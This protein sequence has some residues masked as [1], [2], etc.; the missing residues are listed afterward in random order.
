LPTPSTFAVWVALNANGSY[1]DVSAYLDS[2]AGLT[3]SSGRKN[4]FDPFASGSVTFTLTN[5]DGRFTPDNPTTPYEVPL[6][7]GLRFTWQLNSRVVS[8]YVDSLEPTFENDSA[9]WAK[10]TVT[11]SDVMSRL[12]RYQ[13][14]SLPWEV[15]RAA[16]T[17]WSLGEPSGATQALPANMANTLPLVPVGDVGAI[18]FGD[19]HTPPAG[20]GTGALIN[21]GSDAN[22]PRGELVTK[23][24]STPAIAVGFW[25]NLSRSTTTQPK[26]VLLAGRAGVTP[27]IGLRQG[28]RTS[29][30]ADELFIGSNTF[31]TD[32]NISGNTPHFVEIVFT[33]SGGPSV[34]YVNVAY[35]L[36]GVQRGSGISS[37]PINGGASL[38]FDTLEF[39][40]DEFGGTISH[41]MVKTSA[42]L[43]GNFTTSIYPF[44]AGQADTIAARFARISP[45]INAFMDGVGTTLTGTFSTGTIGPQ[46]I[47][48]K[49]M[50][51]TVT[52]IM[53]VEAGQIYAGTSGTATAPTREVIYKSRAASRPT[54]V[55]S[56]FDVWTDLDG[57]P[58]FIRD[59]TLKVSVVNAASETTN[60]TESNTTL[61]AQLGDVSAELNAPAGT[62]QQLQYLA[63]DRIQRGQTTQLRAASFTIDLRTTPTDRF[64]EVVSLTQGDRTQ[65]Q[66]LPTTQLGYSTWDSLVLGRDEYHDTT[67]NKVTIYA[68]PCIPTYV[69]DTARFAAGGDLK[70]TAAITNS[71]TSFNVATTGAKFTTTELPCNIII[72]REIMT[73]TACTA[74]TP[75]TFTVTRGISSTTAR[76]HVINSPVEVSP[77]AVF[78]F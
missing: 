54:T 78:S 58:D 15:A 71:A 32:V 9:S 22:A 41:I 47:E 68:E 30:I 48:G 25:V 50:L 17:Y 6:S 59:T 19:D 76:A 56:T 73:V 37:T 31:P 23:V 55:T 38:Y 8:G 12:A 75:Q 20:F 40:L 52:E 7:E 5:V 64:T 77:T 57:A 21:D 60:I 16:G 70:L 42:S 26:I 29:S 51:D 24:E 43:S 28:K 62:T 27:R 13:C 44:M 39:G 67:T 46:N 63:Q 61:Q 4:I 65:L 69:F 45:A 1:V 34:Y 66:G 33:T 18:T 74:G 35:F 3:Y 2:D 14:H 49:T 11:C 10:V 72:D 36:D 53:A